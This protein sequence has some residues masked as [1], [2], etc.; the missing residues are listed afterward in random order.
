VW[1]LDAAT[2]KPRRNLAVNAAILHSAAVADG[3]VFVGTLQRGL[4]ALDADS[5]RELWTAA[6]GPGRVWNAPLVVDGPVVFGSRDGNIYAVEAA[7]G[8]RLWAAPT[9]APVLNSPPVP[10]SRMRHRPRR[11]CSPPPLT[12]GPRTQQLTTDN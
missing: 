2:G 5:G 7:T 8:R 1:A 9:G 12:N 3:R 10:T 11:R 4:V 6:T